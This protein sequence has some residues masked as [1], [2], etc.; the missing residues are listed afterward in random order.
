MEVRTLAAVPTGRVTVG[1]A[2]HSHARRLIQPL[3]RSTAKRYPEILLHISENFEG[4][5][6]DD[7]RMGRMDMALLY[8]T[9]P[10]PGFRS[11]PIST[12]PLYLVGQKR[13]LGPASAGLT[14]TIPMLLPSGAHAI[15]QLVEAVYSRRRIRPRIVAEIESFETLAASVAEGLGATVLPRA[16]ATGLAGEHGLALRQLGT[17]PSVITL[18]LSTAEDS[19]L[20]DAARVI[21]Q[22]VAELATDTGGAAPG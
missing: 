19:W 9:I 1:M 5:L 7:L 13:L 22:L 16:V 18:T 21:H 15:R 11:R 10:R 14:G 4:V 20:P 12:E 6:A 8:E 3:L 2:P 17:R